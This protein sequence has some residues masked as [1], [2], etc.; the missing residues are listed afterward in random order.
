MKNTYLTYLFILAFIVS[1]VLSAKV[2][3]LQ[4]P[5]C[6]AGSLSSCAGLGA[7]LIKPVINIHSWNDGEA[8]SMFGTTCRGSLKGRVPKFKWVWDGKFKCDGYP[9]EG[10][11]T[12][13]SKSSAIEAVFTEWMSQAQNAGIF[14]STD[15]VGK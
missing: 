3:L 5:A 1:T 7:S 12:R 15:E 8:Q 6:L 14:D 9:F 2:D 4:V 13:K 11:A 10:R